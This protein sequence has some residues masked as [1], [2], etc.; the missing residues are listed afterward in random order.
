MIRALATGLFALA[1]L[2]P[3]AT[4]AADADFVLG[5][6]VKGRAIVLVEV[7]QLSH[8]LEQIEANHLESLAKL[9]KTQSWHVTGVDGK[10]ST[11]R[12]DAPKVIRAPSDRK[13][14]HIEHDKVV[15]GSCAKEMEVYTTTPSKLVAREP[16]SADAKVKVTQALF[17]EV[18]PPDDQATVG[19]CARGEL[20]VDRTFEEID[21]RVLLEEVALQAV[22]FRLKKETGDPGTRFAA[23]VRAPI[24]GAPR[25]LSLEGTFRA[26]GSDDGSTSV[27]GFVWIQY[28][29]SGTHLAGLLLAEFR[30]GKAGSSSMSIFELTPDAQMRT[31]KIPLTTDLE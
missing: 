19:G 25:I 7:G 24:E 10:T 30:Q 26:P 20:T 3:S 11:R 9:A 8:K 12:F 13:N 4:D 29:R 6:C 22:R 14:P 5:A 18:C 27:P 31:V 2:A 1:L 23:L 15:L 17:D 28:E 21:S 16:S